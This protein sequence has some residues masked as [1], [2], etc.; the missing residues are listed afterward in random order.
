MN[1]NTSRDGHCDKHSIL[2][3]PDAMQHRLPIGAWEVDS[4]CIVY[5]N[6]FRD[7]PDGLNT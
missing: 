1:Y 3:V 2:V 5:I 7:V 6:S 4:S